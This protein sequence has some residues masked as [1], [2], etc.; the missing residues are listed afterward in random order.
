MTAIALD[1]ATRELLDARNFA[2]VATL[3][4]D[5]GPQTSVVW[6]ARDG[7]TVLLSVT[8][9][10]RKARNLVRDPRISLAVFDAG[11]PYHSVEIRGIAELTADPHKTLPKTLSR[12]Y[13]GEDPPP[14]PDEVRRL[15]VR[16]LPQ[17][18]NTFS[19]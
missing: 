16:V 6:I 1:Q 9:D 2:T 19:V 12:K 18:V 17:K 7:D 5:G 10:K 14:E 13:L 4:A 11:N 15:I 8:A 3:N